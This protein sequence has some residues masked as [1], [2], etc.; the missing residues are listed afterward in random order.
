[1]VL[2]V[3]IVTPEKLVAEAECHMVVIPAEAGEMGVL[4]NHAPEIANLSS[5]EV[6]LFKAENDNTASQ[7]FRIKGG[8][9]EINSSTCR[10]LADS[11]ED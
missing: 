9:V 2:K 3:E 8:F 5:G 11:V 7:T 1:M 4:E 10:I 6:K